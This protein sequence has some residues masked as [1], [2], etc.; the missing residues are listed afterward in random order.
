MDQSPNQ[1]SAAPHKNAVT[2][3]QMN[4]TTTKPTVISPLK[5]TPN[6]DAR[7]LKYNG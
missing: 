1:T 2:I 6:I 3:K 4:M 5:L 7:G